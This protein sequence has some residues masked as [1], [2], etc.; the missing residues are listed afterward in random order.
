MS[1]I[2]DGGTRFQPADYAKS[3]EKEIEHLRQANAAIR[4]K[5]EQ[6]WN[7][8]AVGESEFHAILEYI[9]KVASG[10]LRPTTTGT[11]PQ[12]LE[13]HQ[14]IELELFK[15]VL[16]EVSDSETVG[17]DIAQLLQTATD[18]VAFKSMS[19]DD[20][21]WGVITCLIGRTKLYRDE[22]LAH[23]KDAE[24]WR[25]K[26]SSMATAGRGKMIG[27]FPITAD[28][29]LVG[30]GVCLWHPEMDASSL[31][32]RT[33]AYFEQITCCPERGVS[34]GPLPISE[35]YSTKEA[36]LAAKGNR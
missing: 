32:T 3:A 2:D 18:L 11:D 21:I 20:A 25:N 12:P 1:K 33:E 6:Y 22:C 17:T 30:S 26:W 13:P 31:E 29:Y 4:E 19:K 24:T 23:R 10:H 9:H 35:L 15:R 14:K 34:G 5:C 36:A 27:H 8:R 7:E 16:Q 28:G